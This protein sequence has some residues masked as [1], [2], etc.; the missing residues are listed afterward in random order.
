[1]LTPS[2]PGSG[3]NTAP[4]PDRPGADET[5]LS[6]AGSRMGANAANG[7]PV[8]ADSAMPEPKEKDSAEIEP[9]AT[10]A[11]DGPQVVD[12]ESG[13]VDVLEEGEQPRPYAER[14]DAPIADE[15]PTPRD[16]LRRFV[17][18][19]AGLSEV[20]ERDAATYI[21]QHLD[22][23]PWLASAKG[24]D[25]SVQRVL[26]AM[27]QGQGH[28]LERHEGYADDDKLQR[29]VTA[30]ED[31]AQLDDEKW[32]A[33]I[34]GCLP[35]DKDHRCGYAATA[36][37]DPEA[38]A[39]AFVRGIEHPDVQDALRT[40]FEPDARPPKVSLPIEDLLGAGGHRYC[41]GY[42][43][44]PVGGSLL[45]AQDCRSAWVEAQADPERE[46]DIPQPRYAPVD[47]FEGATVEYFFRPTR[48]QDGYEIST[49]YVEPPDSS[50]RGG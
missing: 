10:A 26:V 37:Q 25:L 47:N 3:G 48:A 18:A 8:A 40:P 21:E 7:E 1:M 33:G 14:L 17:P 23:R 2:R 42:M 9:G 50:I 20:S 27:D 28:A 32:V 34:D 49:M 5:Y 11:T 39:T 19:K 43:L 4:R 13:D 44:E 22:Q 12:Q 41:S 35:G 45:A 31:L 30:L 36:I 16:V 15:E 46:P 29:R 38:F 24:C 6:R